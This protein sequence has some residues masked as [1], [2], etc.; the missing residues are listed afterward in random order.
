MTFLSVCD[1]STNPSP[2]TETLVL[3]QISVTGSPLLLVLVFRE[4]EQGLFRATGSNVPG[5]DAVDMSDTG[6]QYIM[7]HPIFFLF[8]VFQV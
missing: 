2:I 5:Y 6:H 7:F 4:N 1:T 8:K 3:E